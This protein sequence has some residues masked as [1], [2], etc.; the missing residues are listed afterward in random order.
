[1]LSA[2]IAVDASAPVR[3]DT[4][5]GVD[6]QGLLGSAVVSL[7][8]GSSALAPKPG[9][10]GEPPLL[11]ADPEA[12]AT[13]GQSAK[14]TLARIDAILDDNAPALRSG[15]ANLNTFSDTLAR[16]SGR[17]DTI[18]AGLEKTMGG[19]KPPPPPQTYDLSVPQF[20][21]PDKPLTAQ[22]AVPEPTALVVFETQRALASPKPGERIPLEPGEWSDSLPK[23]VQAK[24]AQSFEAAGF[25]H[26][27]KSMDGF[28]AD[29]QVVLE[30]RAF[31]LQ[32]TPDPSAQV[33]ISAKLLGADG[34]IVAAQDFHASAPAS[35]VD[36]PAAFAALDQAFGKVAAALV[37]WAAKTI[38]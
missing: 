38:P 22:V 7:R 18:L 28:T 11:I 33:D 13:L 3:E 19:G 27:A 23:V 36:A 21:A 4:H 15:I 8:G 37:L 6:A 30:I 32:L 5:V 14:A 10:A 20:P 24:I 31:E 35:G 2:E 12:S 29:F 1:M 16:N 26:V 34:K 17:V 9:P 25:A